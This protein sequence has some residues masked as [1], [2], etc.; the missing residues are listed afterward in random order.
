MTRERQ[1]QENKFWEESSKLSYGHK[2]YSRK[3]FQVKNHT[4]EGC[5]IRL[6]PNREYVDHASAWPTG[7]RRTKILLLILL[8]VIP[9]VRETISNLN[10]SA[11]RYKTVCS[12]CPHGR[13]H[14]LDA[15]ERNRLRLRDFYERLS[16]IFDTL[17][18][19]EEEDRLRGFMMTTLKKLL[20]R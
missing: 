11:F 6:G 18:I 9:K 7:F 10:P 15:S 19:L 14:K 5:I 8:E 3:A 20:F 2:G 12:K 1:Q 16:K 13:D 17:Q 4:L